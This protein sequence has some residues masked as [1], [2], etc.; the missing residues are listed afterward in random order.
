[1][2]FSITVN[3]LGQVQ[4]TIFTNQKDRN[5]LNNISGHRFLIDTSKEYVKYGYLKH[6][7]KSGLWSYYQ[8]S[9]LKQKVVLKNNILNGPRIEYFS[10]QSVKSF[11]NYTNGVPDGAGVEFYES[12]NLKFLKIYN[13]GP[14]EYVQKFSQK[15]LLI[16][17]C[18]Y[19]SL[20]SINFICGHC[21]DEY[22]SFTKSINDTLFFV[23]N[24]WY[25]NGQRKIECFKETEDKSVVS[26][27]YFDKQGN[28]AIYGRFRYVCEPSTYCDWVKS[29]TW[30]WYNSKK[31]I[32][33]SKSW[34]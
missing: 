11:T 27:N 15:G 4:D 32:I 33:K 24:Q 2:T 12:G 34:D 30:E 5:S 7:V 21:G 13:N 3:S 26:F 9:I 25:E 6:G 14:V 1:M 10:N 8:D 16:R 19:P 20:D 17:E 23:G 18:I 28:L 22:F 29:N 31:E